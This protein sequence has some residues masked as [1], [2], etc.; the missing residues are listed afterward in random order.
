MVLITPDTF[1]REVLAF[2]SPNEGS[3]SSTHEEPRGPFSVLVLSTCDV[4]GI[5]CSHLLQLFLRAWSS[6]HDDVHWGRDIALDVEF[7]KGETSAIG[8]S[9]PVV[10]NGLSYQW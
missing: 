7:F 9:H 3:G 4:D 5:C 10:L 2:I 6:A 8:L 1:V